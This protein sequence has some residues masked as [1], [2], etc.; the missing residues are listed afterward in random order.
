M[1]PRK[2]LLQ[3]NLLGAALALALVVRAQ[4]PADWSVNPN[5]YEFSMTLIFTTSV[6]GWIGGDADIAALFD[7]EGV[8]RGVETA[9]FYNEQTGWYTGLMLVYANSSSLPNLTCAV[10]DVSTDEVLS[11]T[12]T[13]NF[14]SNASLGSLTSPTIISAVG[15]P[16][17][18]CTDAAACNYLETALTDNGSCVYPGCTDETACNFEA[19][20]A[21]VDLSVCIFATPGYDCN[22]DCLSDF[23]G[24][25][26]CDGF[27]VGGCTNPAACNFDVAATDDDC[28]CTFAVYP[29]D[30]NGDC[31][32]DADGDG[33]CDGDEIAGCT[34]PEACEY[35]PDATD[36]DGSCTYCCFQTGT[37]EV[38]GASGFGLAV[39]EF[40]TASIEGITRTAWRIYVTTP[41]LN[42]KVLSVGGGPQG[43]TFLST[44]SS[45][46]QHPN[47]SAL[48]S[49]VTPAGLAEAPDLVYDSWL[50]IGLA[51]AATAPN[52]V[53]AVTSGASIWT[54]LFEFGEDVFLGNSLPGNWS[55]PPTAGNAIAG[56]DHRVLVAQL[57]TDGELSGSLTATILPAG[58][59]ESLDLTLTF[60]PPVCG[61]MNPEACNY[62]SGALLDDGSCA[63][64]LDGRDCEDNCL[65]DADGD[66]VCDADEII[67]CTDPTAPNFNPS[68]TDDGPCDVEGCTYPAA[69][70]YDETAT[71]DDGSCTFTETGTGTGSGSGSDDPPCADLNYDALIGTS[72][73]LILLSQF[74]N[75]CQ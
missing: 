8:C 6:D 17:V 35:N 32:L 70:N 31:Y 38:S 4:P 52:A 27:E 60:T 16:T 53:N 54:T 40:A 49:S 12:T 56:N 69:D 23:D 10:Y 19:S 33:I 50:T 64:A 48:A 68:A 11:S 58:A 42:D 71:I 57:T 62:D 66:D 5:A 13:I 2:I 14:Q 18:G 67:G 59:S 39:E 34:D 25:G 3:L 36:E 41:N 74:G 22:G 26:I 44:T 9:S 51:Q 1:I 73:L 65:A 63:F 61:C 15:D 43:A 24:D 21:C 20:P 30:C 37:T 72:D 75:G 46:Y 29:Y 28:S 47:G 7:S 55:V 45:F